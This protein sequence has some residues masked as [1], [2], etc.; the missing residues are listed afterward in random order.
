MT[1]D[2]KTR[3]S[4]YQKPQLSPEEWKEKK[5]TEK[6]AVYKMIDDTALS[7]VQDA[8]KFKDFLDTQARLDRYSSANVLLIYNQY[9]Q[10]TQLKDFNDWAQEKA[11]V[12]RGA[13]SI[14]ILEPVEYT[15]SDGLPGI[16]YSVKKVF[17]VSQTN[18]KQT[19]P[20]APNLE[21]KKLAAILI[22]ASPVNVEASNELPN[23]QMA[24]F[25]NN[26][27]QTLYIK[28]G[29]SDITELCQ[30]LARE[31]GHAQLA[32]NDGT[33]IRS[34]SAFRAECVGYMLCKKYGV[35]TKNFDIE[36]IPDEWKNK[37]PKE[38]RAELTKIRIA[39]TEIHSCVFEKS[40][41]QTQI[42]SKEQER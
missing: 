37:E 6:D 36:R 10:A 11:S 13:K 15:K 3:K 1:N 7:V 9:P 41:R 29:I 14:S 2:F 28:R 5:Q 18:S 35:D 25:Y 21:S 33:Y 39:M 40:Y 34:D 38:I 22:D 12:R 31:I 4:S 42:R 16:S 20:A 8:E 27:K 30:N 26:D 24:A 23:P 32:D 17:D 19:L